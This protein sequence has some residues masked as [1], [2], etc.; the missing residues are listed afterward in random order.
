MPATH[1]PDV[2]D[3][4]ST[5]FIRNTA[6]ELIDEGAFDASEREDLIQE[7]TLALVERTPKFDPDRAK[8]STFVKT[9]V[10]RRAI[11]L[12]RRQNAACRSDG[13]E[14]ASLDAWID[15]ED[16]QVISL[17]NYIREDQSLVYLAED[18]RSDEERADLEFDVDAVASTLSPELQD[19][20]RRLKRQSQAEIARDLA[21]PRTTLVRRIRKL[22]EAF[23]AAGMR[24]YCPGTGRQ[25]SQAPEE[26]ARFLIQESAEEYHAQS[27]VYLSS[28]QLADF[29][30]C[31]LLYHQKKTGQIA[32]EDRPAYLVG[33]AAHTLVLEG[34]KRFEEEFAVGGPINPVTGKRFGQGTRAFAEW[35]EAQGKPVLTDEQ[36]ELV[37]NMAKSVRSHP[38]AQELLGEGEA[39]G[40]LRAEYCGVPCQIRIDWFHPLLGIVDLKTADSIDYFEA[41]ARRYGYAHQ[42]AFYRAVLAR[43]FCILMPVHFI[44]VEKKPPY[45]CGVWKLSDETLAA[46]QRENEAAIERLKRCEATG[47]WSTGYEERRI[48]A[49]A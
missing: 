26:P 22:R 6:A 34:P 46:A 25:R 35:A 13:R 31:P 49:C 11:S 33:R 7:L 9:V 5:I 10:R 21:I 18:H 8:W 4:F 3:K 27:R 24:D 14:V 48:F 37:V 19:L 41:D 16:G 47:Q 32:D 36:F 17:A 38:L 40:V 42:M 23:D 43:R 28:H 45:R 29:R 12:R 15:D 44:A 20:C 2:T 1:P 30:K 39:E